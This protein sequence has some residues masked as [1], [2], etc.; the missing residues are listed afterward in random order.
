MA[1]MVRKN[2]AGLGE[3]SKNVPQRLK[4]D[5]DLV[6]LLARLKPCPFK[7]GVTKLN[8][9]PNTLFSDL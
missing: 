2:N 6:A 7:T 9:S 4:P 3:A 8:V 5:Q 1:L